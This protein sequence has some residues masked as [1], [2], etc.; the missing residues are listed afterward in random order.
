MPKVTPSVVVDV[1]DRMFPS[2]QF[3]PEGRYRVKLDPSTAAGLGTISRL[4]AEI[5]GELNTLEGRDYAA[6]Y[7]GV[8]GLQSEISDFTSRQERR[9]RYLT[10]VTGFGEA[11]PLDLVREALVK[12]PD[13]A[14]SL[15]TAALAFIEDSE[16][17]ES[18]RLDLSS[19]TNA[20]TGG[21]WKAAT[22]LAGS[23]ME[24]LLLW[25]LKTY[26]QKDLRDAISTL[27][28]LGTVPK[29][30]NFR[31]L[32]ARKWTLHAYVEVAA[33][34]KIIAAHTATEVRQAKEFRNLIHPGAS[35]RKQ[36]KCTRPTAL[37]A[38]AAV[39]FI[40]EDLV[41]TA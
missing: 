21:E 41:K 13:Q 1:I 24:A 8:A 39:D 30:L 26:P 36:Q 34:L 31:D 23:V 19:A 16:L 6:L 7:A 12:C 37:S 25:G 4:T 28:S 11:T 17:R 2:E 40:V 29:G 9:G 10:V 18:L 35:A 3:R 27:V 14:P 22:V 15:Q 32:E 5:P 33:H 38:L 20:F